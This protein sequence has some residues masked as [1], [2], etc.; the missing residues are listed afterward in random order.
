VISGALTT[1][2]EGRDGYSL[3]PWIFLPLLGL[4]PIF[5]GTAALPGGDCESPDPGPGFGRTIFLVCAA[6]AS[7]ALV[8][9][10]C[11]RLWSLY[12]GGHFQP[13][14]D[15]GLLLLTVLLLGYV[16]ANP[17]VEGR[18]SQ[19]F[20]PQV[21][22]GLVGAIATLLYLLA[23]WGR[24]FSVNDVGAVVPVYLTLTFVFVYLPFVGF[25]WGANHGAFC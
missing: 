5:A 22:L 3:A 17:I 2:R 4:V 10:A 23:S 9:A 20:A 24:G 1:E 15:G 21:F 19:S 11:Y 25:V 13:F 16:F 7:L 6:L 14:W 8:G 18:G 12:R